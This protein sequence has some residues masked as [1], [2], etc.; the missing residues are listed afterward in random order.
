MHTGQVTG[1][2]ILERTELTFE[3]QAVLNPGC[4]SVDGTTHMFYR[5]VRG[6][7]Y[8]SV[9]YCKLVEGEVIY[10]SDVPILE[11]ELDYER[12]GIEDPRVSF[13]DGVFYLVYIAYD[14]LNA[15]IAYAT[16][17]E[18]P[19]F[20]KQGVISPPM[21]Y[22]EVAALCKQ[23]E[24]HSVVDF[25]DR[26]FVA[27]YDEQPELR[28][29]LV[30]EKDALLFPRKINGKFALIHR[31]FPEVQVIYFDTFAQLQTVEFWAQNLYELRAHTI[32]QPKY[33][34]ESRHIGGGATPIETEAG[35][36]FIYHAVQEDPDGKRTYHAAAALLNLDDPTEVIGRLAYPLFSPGADFETKGDVNN[37]VFPTAAECQGDRLTIYYGA[38][39]SCIAERTFSKA[40]LLADLGYRPKLDDN[41]TTELSF[42]Y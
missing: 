24:H 25:F 19:Y 16:A 9:G 38:A 35:W 7:N 28:E 27:L 6:G 32:L 37:V 14:G 41:L 34:F 29:L 5:A 39:D 13:I 2:I 12:H 3:E 22:H 31:V 1:R 21:P 4:V 36:L 8:S 42:S 40:S 30:Y 15:R 26:Y 18:L 11:P 17:T 33:W 23:R 10:R 20:T